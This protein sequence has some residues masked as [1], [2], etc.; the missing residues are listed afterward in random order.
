MSAAI[1]SA[2]YTAMRRG[3]VVGQ[4]QSQR[5]EQGSDRAAQP[6]HRAGSRPPEPAASLSSGDDG[7]EKVA[8]FGRS[9]CSLISPD[10]ER[11]GGRGAPAEVRRRAGSADA[12]GRARR[13]VLRDRRRHGPHRAGRS[14]RSLADGRR[15][16][17]EIALVERRPRTATATC[18][19]DVTLLEV[20]R[21]SSTAL[22]R[23]AGGP[24]RIGIRRGD[25]IACAPRP[26]PVGAF[27]RSSSAA[28]LHAISPRPRRLT[29]P[30][31]ST[32]SWKALMSKRAPRRSRRRAAGGPPA[33]DLVGQRLRRAR[34]CTDRPR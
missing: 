9:G 27:S 8:V 29:A 26:R 11:P 17:G 13:R 20:R 21:T 5:R 15:S 1:P 10:R 23:R 28:G 18:V 16:L 31:P 3:A 24:P 7:H 6:R 33:A 25:P 34:R 22:G 12:R 32:A 2:Q 19:T 4:R 14:D 30:E